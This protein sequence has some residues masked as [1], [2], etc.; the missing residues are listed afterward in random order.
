MLVDVKA[1]TL[2]PTDVF[3]T[4]RVGNPCLEQLTEQVML[5]YVDVA[6]EG[7]LE[8]IVM[9]R[10]VNVCWETI[11]QTGYNKKQE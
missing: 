8:R 10:I 2:Y 11:F 3:S 9:K 6:D 5:E 7:F 1:W 4:S